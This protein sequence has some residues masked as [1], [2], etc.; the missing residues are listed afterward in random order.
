MSS[1]KVAIVD[2]G[3]GN[4]LSLERALTQCGFTPYLVSKP[5]DLLKATCVV[6]PGVG[7]FGKAMERLREIKMDHALREFAKLD[8]KLLGICLGMQLLMKD[9]V[10]FGYH[11]GLGII[12]GKVRRI[13]ASTGR[14][15]I[16]VP[17]V[18][19]NSIK[20]TFTL[21]KTRVLTGEYYFVHSY[22]AYPDDLS[23]LWASCKYYDF[24]LP[25]IVG[26]RDVIGM[27]FHPEKSGKAGL[28]ILDLCLR[29][30]FSD[31][32]APTGVYT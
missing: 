7:A 1:S 9:S 10:E 32:V 14:K 25:A 27:Q 29:E 18:G 21:A 2:Y 16:K 31:Y 5:D 11:K 17:H 8:R 28:Q 3:V 15:K 19:W 24:T 6:L 20:P 26:I 4:L 13:E 30:S 22:C 12:P 23:S